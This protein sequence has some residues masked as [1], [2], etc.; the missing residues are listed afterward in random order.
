MTPPQIGDGA[1][2]A[3]LV[4]VAQAAAAPA[5]EPQPN[6]DTK[7][8]DYAGYDSPQ[9]AMAAA[10][11]GEWHLV[12]DQEQP[13]RPWHKYKALFHYV[14]DRQCRRDNGEIQRINNGL[15]PGRNLDAKREISCLFG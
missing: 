6:K 13:D 8:F 4:H 3:A 1:E 14:F 10:A 9:E 11:D 5:E 2:L 12:I 7:V 15:Q